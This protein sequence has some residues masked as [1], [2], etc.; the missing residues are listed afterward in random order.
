MTFRQFAFN[1]VLRNK[2][3][4]AAYYLSSSFSVMIFFLCALFLFHPGIQENMIYDQ[5]VEALQVAEGTVYFFSFFFVIYS[6]GSFL[7]SRKRE[8]GILRLHGMTRKQLNR[9]LFME[10]MA[11]GGASMVTGLIAGLVTAKLFLMAGANMLGIDHLKFHISWLAVL[12]TLGAFA[13]LFLL[14]SICTSGL[15]GNNRLIELFQSGQRSAEPPRKSLALSSLAI[16]LLLLS[17]YLA[18]TSTALTVVIRMVPVTLMTVMGTYLLYTYFSVYFVEAV[19]K[20]RKLFWRR[21]NI[22]TVSALAHR[23]KKNASMLFLVTIISTVT[24]CAIGVFASIHRL[25]HEF[26]QDYLAAVG[27]VSKVNNPTER[28]HLQEIT[29]ELTARGLTYEVISLPIKIVDV[30][31][32][33]SGKGKLQRIPLIAFSDY[34]RLIAAAG[35]PVEDEPLAGRN[36]LIMLGS[37]RERPLLKERQLVSYT[38]PGTDLNLVETGITSHIP[39]PEYLTLELGGRMEGKFSGLVVSDEWMRQLPAV[40]EED[41]YFGFYLDA[42]EESEGIGSALTQNGKV[43]YEANEPYAMTVSGTL[44]AVQTSIYSTMLF[45]ALLVGTV[46][47]IAAGSFL[48]FRLYADLEYD[49]RQYATMSKIGVTWKEI[50]TM[51]TRQIGLLFFV[52]IGMAMIHSLFAFIALQS[53]FNFSIAV[54]AGFI[55]VSFFIVQVIYF[56]FIRRRYLRNVRKAI[57]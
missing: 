3:T 10:N 38:I 41:W 19:R 43:I 16:G 34:E 40:T 25:S 20:R 36:A 53:Y 26:R 35:I 14:I 1:H 46:F 9:M 7:Q 30:L 21:T 28:A 8:L 47:F 44:F 48:Y 52:P 2:R 57:L 37:Q 17:Y 23:M 50:N 6:V 22:V 31:E 51:V 13:V 33:S 56:Y 42:L 55:L 49:R 39:I 12:L 18:A 5:A 15:I 24:F 32:G 27:Y 54:E 45:I 11:I 29:R 4:Y